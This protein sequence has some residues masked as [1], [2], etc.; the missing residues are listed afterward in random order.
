MTTSAPS[1]SEPAS[2]ERLEIT[3][4]ALTGN[5][6][7]AEIL[8]GAPAAR[9]RVRELIP[10]G[11]TVF[12]GTSETLRLSGIGEDVDESGRY[13]SV[14]KRSLTMD[15]AA[16]RDEIRRLLAGPDVIVGSVHAVTETGSLV[17]ASA[18]G[19]QLTGYAGGAFPGRGTVLRLRE[20][21][22]F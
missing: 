22:G 10:G 2:A 21:I 15:R 12:T 7:E 13:D 11:A 18:S 20:A 19:S 5:G 17:I 8:D 3:A 9:S 4:A 6:F 16:Q 14:R 1:F